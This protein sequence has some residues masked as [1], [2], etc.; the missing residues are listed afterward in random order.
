MM[1]MG[2]MDG[3]TPPDPK[4]EAELANAAVIGNAFTFAIICFA[5]HVSPM[6]LDQLG[7]DALL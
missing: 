7:F 6:I 5:I 2:G 3:G 4:K 1:R